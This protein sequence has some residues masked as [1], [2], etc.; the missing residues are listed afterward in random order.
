MPRT[1]SRF[2]SPRRSRS[3]PREWERAGARSPASPP[4]RHR[5]SP[6]A[7]LR[8]DARAA[9]EPRTSR[10]A[11]RRS[12]TAL[13]CRS[14]RRHPI[15]RRGSPHHGRGPR[16]LPASR[17][18]APHRSPA[19][20]PWLKR[21]RPPPRDMSQSIG[22]SISPF[23]VS[24]TLHKPCSGRPRAMR[25]ARAGYPLTTPG[26]RSPSG[27]G[28]RHSRPAARAHAPRARAGSTAVATTTER[29]QRV[30]ETRRAGRGPGGG[31]SDR[32]RSIQRREPARTAPGQP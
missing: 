27:S 5:Q 13:V 10:P 23:R 24:Q 30:T 12:R 21:P 8:S 3:R 18:H 29:N 9:R 1:S 20:L 14:A 4:H 6:P 17:C 26:N 32:L 7:G 19:P 11:R 2:R 22:T 28:R 15:R 25:A 16:S 31:G